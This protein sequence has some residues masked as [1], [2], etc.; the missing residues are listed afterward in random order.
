MGYGSRSPRG[1][2]RCHILMTGRRAV[3]PKGDR[4]GRGRTRRRSPLAARPCGMCGVPPFGVFHQHSSRSRGKWLIPM[5]F[6]PVPAVVDTSWAQNA[7]IFLS[8]PGL[9]LEKCSFCVFWGG[10]SLVGCCYIFVAL[11][12]PPSQRPLSPPQKCADLAHHPRHTHH[13]EES[14]HKSLYTE[15]D[16]DSHYQFY[17]SIYICMYIY[18]YIYVCTIVTHIISCIGICTI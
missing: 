15:T 14:M 7:V 11:L 5:L 3:D 1:G 12:T 4:C 10:T 2:D 9:P 13:T 17:G 16:N 18:I 6:A 8:S